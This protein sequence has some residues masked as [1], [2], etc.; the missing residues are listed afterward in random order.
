MAIIRLLEFSVAVRAGVAGCKVNSLMFPQVGN[1]GKLL[2]AL[3]AGIRLLFGMH[4]LVA[5][6]VL[7]FSEGFMANWAGK[8]FGRICLSADS[9]LGDADCWLCN[10]RHGVKVMRLIH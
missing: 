3:T 8:R 4:W 6:K 10:R 5:E 2:I 7:A 1:A 9:P